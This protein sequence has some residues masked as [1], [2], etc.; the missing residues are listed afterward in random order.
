MGGGFHSED[1]REGRLDQV[2]ATYLREVDS[3]AMPDRRA[4]LT[5]HPEFF[6]ELSDF[7][8]DR[9]QLEQI[10]GPLRDLVGASDR[11]MALEGLD[12]PTH[13]EHLGRI[14][15]YE[16]TDW[17]GQGGMG[18][19]FKAFDETLNRFVAIKLLAPQWSADAAARRRFT[20][21]AQAAAAISHPHVV[22]IHAVGEWRGR[23]YL[24]MEYINGSSLQE[25]LRESGPLELKEILRIG[26]Q[27]AA[28]LAAAHAQGLIHRD[29]KPGNIMLEND[30][31]RVKLTDFGLARAVD[32]TRLTQYG[33]LA[34]TPQYMAPEQGRGEPMDRRAD[35]FSLGSVLYAMCTGRTAFAGESTVEVIRR[36]CDGTPPPIQELNP[37]IPGWLVEIV[38]RLH[39]KDPAG[40]FT[41]AG[42]VADLLER[43]LARSQDPSL[44]PIVHD[45]ARSDRSRAWRSRVRHLAARRWFGSLLLVLL[46]AGITF[47]V[48]R[49]V[50]PP[51]AQAPATARDSEGRKDK[52]VWSALT[53]QDPGKSLGSTKSA[54]VEPSRPKAEPDVP[55]PTAPPIGT[56]LDQLDP[57]RLARVYDLSFLR[58]NYD[59]R[60]L[61]IAAPGGATTLVRPDPRGVRVTIPE[62]LGDSVAIETKFGLRGDF[63]VRAS[64]EVLSIQKPTIGFGVGPE[65]LVKPPGDWDKL[66]SVSRFV[67]PKD[68]IISAVF[69]RKIDGE[70]IV[71]GNWPQ[72]MIKKGT[73]RL[74]RTGPT[75][76]YLIANGD[77]QDF[78]ELFQ[79]EFGTED[80][81]MVRLGAVTGRSPSSADVLFSHLSIHAEELPGLSGGSESTQRSPWALL[82]AGFAVIGLAGAFLWR[83][84]AA[85]RSKASVDRP[86]VAA[87]S[88]AEDEWDDDALS[89][90]E[91]HAAA[92]AA[93]HPDADTYTERPRFRFSLSEGVLNGPFVVWRPMGKAAMKRLG[94]NWDEVC[95][96][97][98]TRFQG[99]YRDGKRNGEFIY[100]DGSGKALIRRYRD[101]ERVG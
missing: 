90:L 34:G 86:E 33:T 36:V 77:S 46:G 43:H 68:T 78:V 89:K 75:M 7:F 80:L 61:R 20:R 14:G 70:T 2:L 37:D 93:S 26:S 71:Q 66:A 24:V 23:P 88:V 82:A 32:D 22:T 55:I 69:L 13:P 49:H 54:D 6:D 45:W 25:R 62:K 76:H 11:L 18:V 59:V 5:R 56:P 101:G 100:R 58:K 41:D 39:A 29:V 19:V 50:S 48:M 91:T 9:D 1:E 81:E 40:R 94:A 17:L 60:W 83:S 44:P 35:L 85:S 51:T 28:G 63:D 96:K 98:P 84:A 31:P 57:A 53:G 67:N 3:G 12:P 79:A 15:G 42:P 47:Q 65:L 87:G 72:T 16:V 97:L 10:T 21:E 64:F 38:T 52:V 4:L 95:E 73:F 30:L 99:G 27:V 74:V 8:A 92:F